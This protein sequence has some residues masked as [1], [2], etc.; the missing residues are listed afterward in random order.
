MKKNTDER[1]VTVLNFL[2]GLSLHNDRQWFAENKPLYEAARQSFDAITAEMIARIAAFEPEVAR[3]TAKD[4]TYRIYR[5]VRFSNDKSPYKTHMGAFVNP[6]GKKSMHGG[7]YIHLQHGYCMLAG[8]SY[9]LTPAILKAVRQSIVDNTAEFLQIVEN[10]RFASLFGE[11]GESRV[12]TVPQGFPRDF[13]HMQYIQ[14]R[15]YS[16]H[17]C[18]PDSFFLSAGWTEKAA[19]VFRVMKPFLDFVNYTVDDY[20]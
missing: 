17:T 3:L 10:P 16:I 7:Y 20:I 14:P 18:M 1:C 5:D 19:E 9:C 2:S 11:I 12:K 6:R 15:D 4:C 8:G 13:P